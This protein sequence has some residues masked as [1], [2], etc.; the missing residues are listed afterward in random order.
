MAIQ[1]DKLQRIVAVKWDDHPFLAL[2]DGVGKMGTSD[3]GIDWSRVEDY[4]GPVLR[5]GAFGNEMF[6]AGNPATGQLRKS[7]DGHAWEDVPGNPFVGKVIRNIVFGDDRF[8]VVALDL[9]TQKIVSTAVLTLENGV[10][11]WSNPSSPPLTGSSFTYNG[12]GYSAGQFFIFGSEGFS[13]S[14]RDV[15]GYD[16]ALSAP[17]YGNSYTANWRK[18]RL[19]RSDDGISWGGLEDPFNGIDGGTSGTVTFTDPAPPHTEVTVAKTD[20]DVSQ[21]T[22]DVDYIAQNVSEAGSVVVAQQTN[23]SGQSFSIYS[24]SWSISPSDLRN[25]FGG[26]A[27]GDVL[28]PGAENTTDQFVALGTNPDGDVGYLT[29][30]DGVSWQFTP[31]GELPVGAGALDI[32]F[33]ENRFVTAKFA[34]IYYSSLGDEWTVANAVTLG[35]TSYT[36]IVY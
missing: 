27:Y 14:F 28:L 34:D 19:T 33:G 9:A 32:V 3:D 21:A 22:T 10:D 36:M 8:L 2:N 25:V 26:L 5:V 31:Q 6:L 35:A 16:F 1:L 18:S 24:G 11:V 13:G 15:I 30:S 29:S 4:S 23:V 7:F 12:A 17:I 20:P